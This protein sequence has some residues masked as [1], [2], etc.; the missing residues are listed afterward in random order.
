LGELVSVIISEEEVEENMNFTGEFSPRL[1]ARGDNN[2]F[3]LPIEEIFESIFLPLLNPEHQRF[4][5]IST[6]EAIIHVPANFKIAHDKP[7]NYLIDHNGQR[8]RLL[9][10]WEPGAVAFKGEVMLSLPFKPDDKNAFALPREQ[11][12]FVEVGSKPEAPREASSFN[13]P[14]DS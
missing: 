1:L 11:L 13:P 12:T 9:V 7:L 6:V 4:S 3:V 8:A 2:S 10:T 14:K 5:S